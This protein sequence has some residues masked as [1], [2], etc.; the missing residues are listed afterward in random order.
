MLPLNGTIFV[1]GIKKIKLRL[2]ATT[3]EIP[4]FSPTGE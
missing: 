2:S 3:D 4:H 1:Q